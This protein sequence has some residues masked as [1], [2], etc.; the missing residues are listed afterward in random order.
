MKVW[1]VR[2]L[3]IASMSLLTFGNYYAYDIPASVNKQLQSYLGMSDDSF[4]REL[5]GYYSVYSLPNIILP[6]V[7]G[8]LISYLGLHKMTMILLCLVSLG[9]LMFCFGVQLRIE[10]L[11]WTGRCVLGVGGESLGVAQSTFAA[12]W[13]GGQENDAD[14]YY[15]QTNGRYLALTMALNISLGRLGSVC[16]DLLSPAIAADNVVSACYVGFMMCLFSLI[17]GLFL[18]WLDSVYRCSSI[19][20]FHRVTS[21]SL[22]PLPVQSVIEEQPVEFPDKYAFSQDLL[23]LPHAFWIVCAI[24]VLTYGTIVPFNT[25]HAGFLMKRFNMDPVKA[26]QVMAIPDS[27]SM[28]LT[29][30]VG[31]LTDTFGRRVDIVLVCGI[32]LASVHW[33]LGEAQSSNFFLPYFPLFVLGICYSILLLYWPMITLLTPK[34]MIST[35]FGIASCL[36]NLSLTVF[37]IL[38]AAILTWD[39]TY[40]SVEILFVGCAMTSVLLSCELLRLDRENHDNILQ[41]SFDDLNR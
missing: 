15:A 37:P 39:S 1:L 36:L 29:P 30:F 16:N 38:V 35:S 5:N 2:T 24:M 4:A 13:F 32:C 40:Y 34:N 18:I 9:Q 31:S 21:I 22:D 41:K 33:V 11:I 25:I 20:R 10:W 27:I 6:F 8:V 14:S 26:A 17:F 7:G 23:T 19:A 28:I 12:L 3:V